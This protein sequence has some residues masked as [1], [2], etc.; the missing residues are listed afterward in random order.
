MKITRTRE[1]L[2]AALAELDGTR[3]LV[4]T[5]GALHEGHLSLVR[6]ARELAGHVVV[7]IYV[8]PL[9]FGPN[10]DFDA[11]PRQLDADVA[12]LETVG[13][14]VVFAPSDAEMYPREPLVRI[15]PGPAATVLEGQTR[16]GHFA[17]VLQVV[18][19]VMNLVRPDYAMFGQK[20]AQQLAIVT[21]MVDDLDMGLTIVPVP[22]ARDDD[23]VAKS[24]RNAYLSESERE[25]A[26]VL[27]RALAVGEDAAL[28]GR[29]PVEAHMAALAVLREA[30]EES[31]GVVRLDYLA[32]VDPRSF[33]PLD[34]GAREGLLAV[35]AWVGTTRLIDNRVLQ[36][37][38]SG[39]ESVSLDVGAHA[40]TDGAE[41][42]QTE[43]DAA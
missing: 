9:Q 33:M 22:I 20:D 13:V 31:G 17:G 29:T 2:A 5:M 10:E 11:Y 4:M 43:G 26:R 27:N 41:T 7:S 21:S 42:A 18:H 14:E 39:A 38:Q 25:W 24:S 35:A 30:G 16:P 1:E 40:P 15:D 23:G 12:L 36:F 37:G 32:M 3:G 19:K 28:A 8:N 6:R 34:A